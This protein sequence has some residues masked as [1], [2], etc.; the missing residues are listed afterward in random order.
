[1]KRTCAISNRSLV[2]SSSAIN[3]YQRQ[4]LHG[5]GWARNFRRFNPTDP[6]TC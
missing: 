3:D 2:L 4:T 5:F 1:M 6:I